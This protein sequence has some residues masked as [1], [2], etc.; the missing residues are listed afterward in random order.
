MNQ[1]DETLASLTGPRAQVSPEQLQRL[2]VYMEKGVRAVYPTLRLKIGLKDDVITLDWDSKGLN[3]RHRIL[4]ARLIGILMTNGIRDLK[5]LIEPDIH[6]KP[7]P[8]GDHG[9]LRN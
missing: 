8:K 2:Q 3:E 4:V 7:R 9:M 6:F 5:I 1:P